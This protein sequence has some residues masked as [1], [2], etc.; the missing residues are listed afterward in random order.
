MTKNRI[1]EKLQQYIFPFALTVAGIGAGYLTSNYY[2]EKNFSVEKESE[3]KKAYEKG[4]QNGLLDAETTFNN[5]L[6]ERLAKKYSIELQNARKVGEA[7][8]FKKGKDEGYRQGREIGFSEGEKSGG[9]KVKKVAYDQGFKDGSTEGQKLG[10]ETGKKEGQA[11]GYKEGYDLAT[12]ENTQFQNAEKNWRNYELAIL[13]VAEYADRLEKDRN[14]QELRESFLSRV[15]SLVI[16]AK[17]LQT[18]YAQQ[19]LSFNST[20]DDLEDA[21]DSQNFPNMRS[22]SRTLRESAPVKKDL[23]LQSKKQIIESFENLEKTF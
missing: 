13:S 16:S 1:T 14:N 18:S 7:D 3:I 11:I 10:Y 9:E 23:F 12:Q 6:N 4:L 2:Y 20:M 5:T 17:Q 22:Y 19:S 8:G 21:L 15:R